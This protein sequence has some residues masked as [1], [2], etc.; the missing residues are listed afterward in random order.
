MTAEG[1]PM[2]RVLI[3][4]DH[5]V[6]RR[7]LREILSDERDVEVSE[8]ADAH[9]ALRLVREQTFELAVLDIDLPGK[10]GLDLLHDVKRARPR[11]P[12]LILS[13]YPEDQFA[14]RVLRCGADGFLC[15][16]AAPEEL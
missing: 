16:D 5:A 2:I 14:I 3:V 9:E 4:D 8:A 10:S 15:K 1:Q 13:V 11:L 6:V 7:G 12:V